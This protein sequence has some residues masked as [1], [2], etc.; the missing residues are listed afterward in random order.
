MSW[1]LF[2]NVKLLTLCVAFLGLT[3]GAVPPL[4]AG[5]ILLTN[6]SFE[7]PA[8]SGPG[9]AFQGSIPG[10]TVTGVGGAYFP[11]MPPNPTHDPFG[12]SVNFVPDGNQVGFAGGSGSSGTDSL[13][14][15]TGV[16]V[17][18]GTQYSLSVD[19]GSRLTNQGGSFA[20]N[21]TVELLAGSTV[22][23][24]QSGSSAVGDGNFNLVTVNATGSGTGNLGIEFISHAFPGAAN[25]Q[26]FFDNVSLN[27]VVPEPSSL[28]LLGIS[29]AGMA[30]YSWLRRGQ[31]QRKLGQLFS[32]G[33]L[34]VAFSL[35]LRR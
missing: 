11:S 25:S 9:T 13:F 35:R 8:Q 20:S 29:V 6:A 10:W 14:Q 4:M 2:M 23:G 28:T 5:P 33:H 17:I 12:P 18:V 26:T 16:A 27:T 21:W 3:L 24:Q 31:R 19:V 32:P 1:R 34:L 22:I 30:G 15:N 7:S